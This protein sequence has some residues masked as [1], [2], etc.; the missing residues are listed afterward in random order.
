MQLQ[1][2][3]KLVSYEDFK[4]APMVRKV[5][6]IMNPG[7][8]S[9]TYSVSIPSSN[10]KSSDHSVFLIRDMV[11]RHGFVDIKAPVCIKL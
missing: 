5:Q 2:K 7:K 10:N 11:P 3:G 1:R 8:R 9:G 4:I 6:V